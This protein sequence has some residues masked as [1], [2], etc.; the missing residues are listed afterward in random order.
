MSGL[1]AKIRAWWIAQ[2][3][4]GRAAVRITTIESGRS[5]VRASRDGRIVSRAQESRG[6]L[7]KMP[8]RVGEQRP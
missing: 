3:A 5:F 1:M 8:P 2:P 4:P 7:R 6:G